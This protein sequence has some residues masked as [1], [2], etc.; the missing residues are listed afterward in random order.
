[1]ILR[2]YLAVHCLETPFQLRSDRTRFCCYAPPSALG[3]T[4][5][6]LPVDQEGLLAKRDAVLLR[7]DAHFKAPHCTESVA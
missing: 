3:S 4:K 6:V 2:P 1:M 7:L 5:G